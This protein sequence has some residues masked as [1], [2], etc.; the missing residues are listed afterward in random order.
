[1]WFS[2]KNWKNIASV[3]LV[4]KQMSSCCSSCLSFICSLCSFGQL[5]HVTPA[6]HLS[7]ICRAQ[8]R[9]LVALQVCSCPPLLF[10][11]W[12][13][14]CVSGYQSHSLCC[15]HCCGHFLPQ[16]CS[17]HQASKNQKQSRHINDVC[18]VFTLKQC[19]VLFCSKQSLCNTSTHITG[20]KRQTDCNSD[21]LC[22][23]QP[24]HTLLLAPSSGH[25]VHPSNTGCVT[26]TCCINDIA[27]VHS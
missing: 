23:L 25:C 15:E 27:C 13:R 3:L 1:M 8:W 7:P 9:L 6:H 19:S 22:N 11:Q 21:Y 26:N 24:E 20:W 18:G 16:N 2:I 12:W 14:V 10:T 5:Q 17:Q 4:D